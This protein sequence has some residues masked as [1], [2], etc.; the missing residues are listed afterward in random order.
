MSTKELQE[1]IV[2]NMRRW[3]HM[4]NATIAATANVI[5]KTENPIVRIVMEIIQRDSQMHHRVQQLI[6]DSLTSK[7][8]SL[9]PE[10]LE[11]V[12]GLI[13][14]HIRLERQ[15]VDMAEEA[16]AALKGKKMVV[17]EYLLRYLLDDENKHNHMLDSLEAGAHAA[18]IY[19]TM[20]EY[21]TGKAYMADVLSILLE[22][23]FDS[24]GQLSNVDLAR[25]YDAYESK[26]IEAR[27]GITEIV[28]GEVG[29]T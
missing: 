23:D 5:E 16:L 12:W 7:T 19:T 28:S 20:G 11:K 13:E 10:E 15:T 22:A 14:K 25:L 6:A 1:R 17:Q 26:L 27:L 29:I 9:T 18:G 21:T 8:V 3:Q 24:D 2:D 4:E